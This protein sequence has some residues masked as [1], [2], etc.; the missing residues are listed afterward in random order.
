MKPPLYYVVGNLKMNMLSHEEA[1]Q[2]I[3]VLKRE[4]K[5]RQYHFTKGILC[6]PFLYLREFSHLPAGLESGAQDM[7]WEKSGAYTGEI[8]PLMIKNAGAGAVIIGHSERRAL[9]GETDERVKQKVTAAL[10]HLLTPVVC[11]GE[12]AEERLCQD[13]DRV[14]T[15]QVRSIFAGISKLQAEKI[16]LAYEPRWAIGTDQLPTS[17]EILSVRILIRKILIELFDAELA[18]KI[19]VLYGGSVK[20][21]FLSTVS[22]EGG[23][24][25]VLVGRESLFPYEI[26]KMM[27]MLEEYAEQEQADK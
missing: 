4:I 7:F 26:V 25:G 23:M 6:P 15:G 16:I 9:Q 20:S 17:Q 2:Y 21:A 19:I 27:N 12:T 13:T 11:I 8:S 14:L 22:W 18:G 3:A 24:D 5:A 1:E 10:K